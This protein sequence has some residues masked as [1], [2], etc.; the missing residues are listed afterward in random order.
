MKKLKAKKKMNYQQ[1]KEVLMFKETK[2]IKNPAV[3]K[4]FNTHKSWEFSIKTIKRWEGN[5]TQIFEEALAGNTGAQES[6]I[7]KT[8]KVLINWIKETKRKG[9]F[10]MTKAIIQINAN[11]LFDKDEEELFPGFTFSNGRH[12]PVHRCGC[13]LRL[14]KRCWLLWRRR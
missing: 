7:P 3:I 8:E 6:R 2:K 9:N 1:K 14:A 11:D 4:Y 10:P 5:R 13:P 12:R